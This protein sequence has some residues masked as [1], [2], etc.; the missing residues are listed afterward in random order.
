MARV[1]RLELATSGVTGQRSN[2]L[3]YT[4]LKW[5]A[6]APRKWELFTPQ[7]FDCQARSDEFLCNAKENAREAVFCGKRLF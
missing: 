6:V 3:S 5:N 2:Q 4:P 1:T 7:P